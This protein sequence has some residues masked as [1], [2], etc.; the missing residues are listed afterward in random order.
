VTGLVCHRRLADTSARLD[1]SVGASGPHDFAVR[2]PG[3]SRQK[4]SPR[5]SHP[6]LTFVTI[7]KRPSVW[8]GTARDIKLIWVRWEAI[9]RKFRNK[10]P[11][12]F[13]EAH[14]RHAAMSAGRSL[15]G[16]KRR[17][18]GQSIFVGID[19]R[20]SSLWLSIRA[21]TNV[22]RSFDHSVGDMPQCRARGSPPGAYP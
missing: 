15:S 9:F 8:A 20:R 3:A 2:K 7:A 14:L 17:W 12:W 19:R 1:A 22:G 6:N 11:R 10:L 18:R 13:R 21:A 4:R 16:R 5:P